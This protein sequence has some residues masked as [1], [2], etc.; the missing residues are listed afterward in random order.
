M[1]QLAPWEVRSP[2]VGAMLNPALGS[3]LLS[4]AAWS[5]KRVRGVPMPFEYSFLILPLVLHR[6]TRTELPGNTNS[7][8]TKW[9]ADRPLVQ[10]AFPARAKSLVPFTREALRYGLA[11]QQLSLDTGLLAGSSRR[12]AELVP[13]SEL[14]Q[15]V[16]A[17][18]LVGRW[19]GKVE[20]PSTLFAL[21]GVKP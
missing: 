1:R 12:D 17:S 14:D 20:K 6:G 7:L 4:A 19:L 3:L 15:L 8:I 18:A 16:R 13:D 11:S 9:V 5:Y 21:L 10:A 2:T